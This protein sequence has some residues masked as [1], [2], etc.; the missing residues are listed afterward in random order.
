M[1]IQIQKNKPQHIVDKLTELSICCIL[2]IKNERSQY[3]K[4]EES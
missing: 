4:K 3:M 2:L 1:E